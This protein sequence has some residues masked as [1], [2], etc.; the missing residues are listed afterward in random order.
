MHFRERGQ[1]VQII[2]TTYDQGS[3]K[4]KNEIVGRLMKN[5]PEISDALRKALST[6]ERREVETWIKSYASVMPLKRELAARTLPESLALAEDWFKGQKGDDA[7]V[8][9]AG[10]MTAW[11]HLRVVMKR[12]GLLE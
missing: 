3:K 2:R 11:T 9:A 5:K 6:E 12:N 1:I 10:I 7:R 8:L 4:G